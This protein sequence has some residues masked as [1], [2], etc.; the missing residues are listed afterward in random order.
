MLKAIINWE[1]IGM[2]HAA[3]V[4]Y[5]IIAIEPRFIVMSALSSC[6]QNRSQLRYLKFC[7]KLSFTVA[8]LF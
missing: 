2:Q 8:Q 3:T 6:G 1:Y 5:N 4:K 7:C